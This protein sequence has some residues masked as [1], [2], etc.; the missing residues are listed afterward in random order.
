MQRQY[1]RLSPHWGVPQCITS[2]CSGSAGQVGL[3]WSPEGHSLGRRLAKILLA[4][5][6][7]LLLLWVVEHLECCSADLRGWVRVQSLQHQPTPL[8]ILMHHLTQAIPRQQ[9]RLTCPLYALMSHI[10]IALNA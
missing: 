2:R 4:R 5:L 3:P 8:V 1:L 10:A 6:H 7:L 9:A